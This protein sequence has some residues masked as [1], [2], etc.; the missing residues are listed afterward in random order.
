MRHRCT[1]VFK[2]I[3]ESSLL[4]YCAHMQKGNFDL[5]INIITII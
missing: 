4:H 5:N 3:L 2:I 1:F